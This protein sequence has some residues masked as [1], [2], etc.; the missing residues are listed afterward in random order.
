MNRRPGRRC[1]LAV[2]TCAILLLAATDAKSLRPMGVR[3]LRIR[4]DGGLPAEVIVT[5]FQTVPGKTAALVTE[6]ITSYAP[7]QT[8]ISTIK[9]NSATFPVQYSNTNLQ[10]TATGVA[11]S[12][13]SSASSTDS[14]SKFLRLD[15]VSLYF[16]V[17]IYI[18]SGCI[19]NA[20]RP[21]ADRP[22]KNQDQCNCKSYR[23]CFLET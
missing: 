15:D 11:P 19:R 14:V 1:V 3:D 4:Q 23:I 18:T 9:S 22:L 21:L 7:Q 8:L 17:H 20:T 16:R 5:E 10:P 6:K 12:R 13:G 2:W